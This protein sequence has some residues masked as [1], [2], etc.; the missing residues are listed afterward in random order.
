VRS[1][2]ASVPISGIDELRKDQH[3][4]HRMP[5]DKD[6]RPSKPMIVRS[7][8]RPKHPHNG[9][10]QARAM[11]LK[12]G[13][14]PPWPA[15]DGIH[16]E[17]FELTWST[18]S[19]PTTFARTSRYQ[20]VFSSSSRFPKSARATTPPEY[21]LNHLAASFQ[22]RPGFV[23]ANQKNNARRPG[24]LDWKKNIHRAKNRRAS[25]TISSK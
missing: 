3:G 16:N 7:S 24:H 1:S 23:L 2:P 12:M 19:E 5:W 10:R 11:I 4:P 9:R 13:D 14:V 8:A 25:R 15:S 20:V 21:V 22:E 18:A 6:S 17:D